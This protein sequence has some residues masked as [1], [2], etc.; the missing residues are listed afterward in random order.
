MLNEC[1]NELVHYDMRDSVLHP[2][3]AHN[4]RQVN[5]ILTSGGLVFYIEKIV[6]SHCTFLT[7]KDRKEEVSN[8]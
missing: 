5:F 7:E 3:E 2:T 8:I 1:K 4:D 6:T